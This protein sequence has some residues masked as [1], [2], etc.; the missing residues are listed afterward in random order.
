MATR[1]RRVRVVV[2]LAPQ[3]ALQYDTLAQRYGFTRSELYRLGLEYGY[4]AVARWCKKS[5]VRL[6][7]SDV[8]DVDGVVAD[9]GRGGASDLGAATAGP[10]ARSPVA[11]LS[12]FAGTFVG[13]KDAADTAKLRHLFTD[14]AST[15]GM[16]VRQAEVY[17]DALVRDVHARH[18][19][20][21]AEKKS[22]AS[23]RRGSR[24][25]RR[26]EAAPAEPVAPAVPEVDPELAGSLL[27]AV[28]GDGAEAT[29]AAPV[30]AD[31]AA[32]TDADVLDLD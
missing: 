24:S 30:P 11:A 16:A 21:E 20:A 29:P 6:A 28:D 1:P 5:S 3:V 9:V 17:V 13:K 23:G 4:A 26:A 12:R 18:L 22:G 31:G 10:D 2:F 27:D 14:H 19:A 8:V 7:G 32:S 25:R 15:L